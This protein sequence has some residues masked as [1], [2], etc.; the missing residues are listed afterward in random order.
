MSETTLI[1][2]LIIDKLT[3]FDEEL[4]ECNDSEKRN[5]IINEIKKYSN[6]LNRLVCEYDDKNSK[7]NINVSANIPN[8]EKNQKPL[9]QDEAYKNLNSNKEHPSEKINL[10]DEKISHRKRKPDRENNKY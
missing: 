1:R 2:R 6:E 10:E 8:F 3:Q 4:S 5:Q 9:K 7:A